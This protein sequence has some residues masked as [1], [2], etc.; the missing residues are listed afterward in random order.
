MLHTSAAYMNPPIFA[1]Y[2]Q[3]LLFPV[4]I[5]SAPDKTI[6]RVYQFCVNI[7]MIFCTDVMRRCSSLRLP[8]I[9]VS[10]KRPTV[11]TSPLSMWTFCWPDSSGGR[12]RRR[13]K[14]SQ[15]PNQ[16]S[17][18]RGASRAPTAP[19][20]RPLAAPDSNTGGK[21]GSRSIFILQW[22]PS[23]VILGRRPVFL[24]RC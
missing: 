13:S 21:H 24:V 17:E 7:Q 23:A 9:S 5:Y 1:L 3:I 2:F 14:V 16:A 6:S 20:T 11:E 10:K 8:W 12:W 19:C 18:L 4:N 22:F 15:S